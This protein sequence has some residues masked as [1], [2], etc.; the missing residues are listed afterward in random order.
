LVAF[1]LLTKHDPFM[2]WNAGFLALCLN[3]VVTGAVSLLT[4]SREATF[5]EA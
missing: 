5:D 1:L 2:G 3:F 4:T